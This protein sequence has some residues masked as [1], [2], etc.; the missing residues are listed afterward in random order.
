MEGEGAPMSAKANRY[1]INFNSIYGLIPLINP[2]G[3]FHYDPS[4]PPGSQFSKFIVE[5][6]AY[7]F[8]I[9]NAMDRPQPEGH[10]ALPACFPSDD[11]AGSFA[12]LTNPSCTAPESGTV[13]WQIKSGEVYPGGMNFPAGNIPAQFQILA[14][15]NILRKWGAGTDPGLWAIPVKPETFPAPVNYVSG[16]FTVSVAPPE[17]PEH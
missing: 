5:A 11:S 4:M 13:T 10:Q 14:P 2:T 12:F 17:K 15:P 6:F 3:S 8:D 9:T 1:I 7:T 16:T